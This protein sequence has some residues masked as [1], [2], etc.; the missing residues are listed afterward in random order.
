[1]TWDFPGC[2]PALTAKGRDNTPPPPGTDIGTTPDR[3]AQ[4]SY[5]DRPY[6][7]RTAQWEKPQITTLIKLRYA[8]L[9]QVAGRPIG[10]NVRSRRDPGR[11][12]SAARTHDEPALIA[13]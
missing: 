7:S 12:V 2:Q 8:A 13:V 11:F 3:P 9:G 1:M 5:P 6:A 4:S 10:L